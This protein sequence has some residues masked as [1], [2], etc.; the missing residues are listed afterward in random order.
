MH[1]ATAYFT[2]APATPITTF[3]RPAGPAP[4]MET[5][6]KASGQSSPQPTHSV[7]RFV[8][9][10]S[11]FPSW[12]ASCTTRVSPSSS[13]RQ[14]RVGKLDSRHELRDADAGWSGFSLSSCPA[15]RLHLLE[16][17][18][19][20]QAAGVQR[21]LGCRSDQRAPYLWPGC[22]ADRHAH[23]RSDALR[24]EGSGI[25]PPA[26]SIRRRQFRCHRLFP[27][28]GQPG[29]SRNSALRSLELYNPLTIQA[30]EAAGQVV[31]LETDLTTPLA[32]FLANSKL[33]RLHRLHRFRARRSDSRS[34]RHPHARSLPAWQ[35]SRRPRPRLAVLA[36]DL[37]AGHKRFAGRPH[38]AQRY[39]FWYYYYPTGLPYL[40]SAA[41]LRRELEQ[42]RQRGRS[43]PSGRGAGHMVFVG[44][45]MGGLIS[46]LMTMDSGDDFWKVVSPN[47]PSTS[48]HCREK[49]GRSC[50]GHS[51]STGKVV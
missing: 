2:S 20:W 26:P 49:T 32:Y 41:E 48:S 38:V 51:F 13:P 29:R 19:V 21:F 6:L 14:E 3:R 18:R 36:A 24:P 23:R 9:L 12:L 40:A 33:E 1:Y 7:P 16:I 45:S 42:L 11:A 47:D 37:G 15:R 35:D 4:D 39:Q 50:N 27:L 10:R 43:K 8:D 25:R 44:H 28:R 22:T 17:R 46:K 34:D 31:P 30:I 5:S